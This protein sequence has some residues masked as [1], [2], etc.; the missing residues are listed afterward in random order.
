ML[1]LAIIALAGSV[2]AGLWDLKTTEVPDEIPALMIS[3]GVFVWYMRAVFLGQYYELFLSIAA[4]TILLATGLAMYRRGQWGGADAWILGAVGYLLPVYGG[5]LFVIDYIFNFFIVSIAYM[6]VYSLV[7]GVRNPKLFAYTFDEARKGSARMLGMAAMLVALVLS[8]GFYA[9]IP[10]QLLATPLALV[11]LLVFFYAYAKAIEKY[12]FR[13][14]IPASKLKPG[15][16]LEKM[17]WRGITED[18]ISAVRKKHKYVVIKEGVRFVP[19]FAITL[20]MTL[21]YGNLLVAV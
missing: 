17:V 1:E 9:N 18:E 16:V 15:D 20:I 4:G 7:L 6:V 12:A 8:A 5:N 10:L 19:V 11:I 2:I 21:A 3:S 13:K 14:K